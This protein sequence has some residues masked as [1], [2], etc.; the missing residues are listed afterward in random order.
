VDAHIEWMRSAFDFIGFKQHWDLVFMDIGLPGIDGMEAAHLLR[1]R[2][3]ESLLIFVTDLAQFAVKGYEVDALDFVVKPVNYQSLSMRLDR[4]MRI[5]AGKQVTNIYLSTRFGARVFPI[6]DLVFAEV[7]GH[8]LE[9]HLPEETITVRGTMSKLEE[10]LDSARFIRISNSCLINADRIHSI[11]GSIVRMSTGD[12]L[13]ISR[14]KKKSALEA[15][16]SYY[17]GGS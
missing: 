13:A 12:E 4:A 15:L 5:L 3:A 1:E 9:Y 8:N 11:N 17:G 16:A 14:T 7:R 6:T 2:D 10:D